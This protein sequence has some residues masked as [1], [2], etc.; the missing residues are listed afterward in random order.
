MALQQVEAQEDAE[1]RG[2]E[3]IDHGAMPDDEPDIDDEP[4]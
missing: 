2:D 1:K 4:I 3:I